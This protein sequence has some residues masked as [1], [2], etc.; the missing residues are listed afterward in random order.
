MIY[1]SWIFAQSI[2]RRLIERELD[3]DFPLLHFSSVLY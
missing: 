1:H 3:S 2:K